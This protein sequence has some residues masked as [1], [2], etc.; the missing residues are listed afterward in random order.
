MSGY[1]PPLTGVILRFSRLFE[2]M[3]ERLLEG[4]VRLRRGPFGPPAA[5]PAMVDWLWHYLADTRRRLV[6]LHARFAA[7][8]LS[9]AP[10]RRA[11]ARP[12]AGRETPTGA[13]SEPRARI[14][15]PP[16]EVFSP[17]GL[18]CYATE[19][20][21][22]VDDPETRA[23]LAASPQAGKLLRP[24]WRKL[25]SEPLPEAL[26]LPPTPRRARQPR[27]KQPVA[28]RPKAAPAA[29]EATGRAT[30]IYPVSLW[31]DPA[32]MAASPAGPDRPCPPGWRSFGRRR[33]RLPWHGLSV[34]NTD[35]IPCG[36]A[37]YGVTVLV[38]PLRSIMR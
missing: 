35:D 6:A 28:A 26:R 8:T 37:I 27:V 10:R 3:R 11:V 30:W 36:W 14:R 2:V 19:L 31:P 5:P 4:A 12:A 18:G 22:L 25:S 15:I 9:A 17:Y 20:R 16:V 32:P 23:L 38:G 34:A 7:G 29:P 33:P 1:P 24:L 21:E 13:V